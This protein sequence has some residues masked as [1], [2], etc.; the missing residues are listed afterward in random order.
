MKR[1]LL[2]SV[3]A[4]ALSG[5]VSEYPGGRVYDPYRDG[6]ERR[7]VV[8]YQDRARPRPIYRDD[9]PND[10]GPYRGPSDY[11]RRDDRRP[12]DRRPD[13]RDDGPA[14]RDP[15]P[16]IGRGRVS[17][18]TFRPRSETRPPRTSDV[19]PSAG[20]PRPYIPP[21]RPQ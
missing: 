1:F 15:A 16:S 21:V 10:R 6:Y 9:R 12:S 8:V 18:Q 11:D 5:C 17:E 19:R 20:G 13:Y 2:L 4:V 14:R 3:M 7:R